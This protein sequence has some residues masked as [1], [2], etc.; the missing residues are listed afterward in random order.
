MENMAD[1]VLESLRS[2][3]QYG[4]ILGQ[5][6]V[7]DCKQE[8]GAPLPLLSAYQSQDSSFLWFSSRGEAATFLCSSIWLTSLF[9]LVRLYAADGTLHD[10]KCTGIRSP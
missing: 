3:L 1:S 5:C 4:S 2:E 7:T 8:P 10:G 6:G 9:F